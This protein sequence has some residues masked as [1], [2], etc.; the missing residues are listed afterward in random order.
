[1]RILAIETSCDETAVAVTEGR[2]VL[3]NV[4][5]SQIDIHKEYGGVYP[6]LA[7]RAH[8]EKIDPVILKALKISGVKMEKIGAIAVTAG[9]GLVVA[10]EV[11]L[12]KGKELARVYRKPLIPIDHTEGHIYSCFGQN[13]KGKPAREFKFP[14]LALIISGGYTG[15]ILVKDH[16]KYEILGKTLDDAVGEAFDKA[17]KMI[18][19]GYPGGPVIE[20]LA[21]KG[22]PGFLKLPIP[23]RAHPGF[24][25]SY[26]GLKTAFY[27]RLAK[28]DEKK[29]KQNLCS[30]AASFQETAFT[31]LEVR[32]KKALLT[33]GVKQLVVG[34]GVIANKVLRKKIRK[35]S[36]D[37][38]VEV[39]FPSSEKLVGDNAA[40]IGVAGHFKYQRGIY[41]EK[42][43]DSLDR[44][45]RPDL[46][47]WVTNP[48]G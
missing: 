5:F 11:G 39:L 29:I 34:G 20:A 24:D 44:I 18:G 16:L 35:L 32:L 15:L 38:E 26:S 33:T 3:S 13:R 22:D 12:E 43:F 40:M 27:N 23:M 30:L 37:L 19:L 31:A 42:N 7:K 41:L 28:M 47:M 36:R 1:M 48:R 10:L 25:F 8:Q 21:K 45:A 4:I 9:Q 46:K 6:S 17:C 2:R 14:L